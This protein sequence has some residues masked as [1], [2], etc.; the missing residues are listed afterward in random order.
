MSTS[1][2]RSRDDHGLAFLRGSSGEL[3]EAEHQAPATATA[4]KTKRPRTALGRALKRMKF[5]QATRQGGK[6]RE[7]NGRK[8]LPSLKGGDIPRL[9]CSSRA[10]TRGPGRR[11]E[12]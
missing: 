3:S 9:P 10:G 8:W 4:A 11:R 5:L 6:P 2:R 1:S 12:G 7:K